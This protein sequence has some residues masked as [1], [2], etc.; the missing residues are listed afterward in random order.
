MKKL[1]IEFA[2]MLQTAPGRLIDQIT[3]RTKFFT[4]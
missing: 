3:V 1:N 4:T 2:E